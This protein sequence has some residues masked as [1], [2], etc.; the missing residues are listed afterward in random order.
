MNKVLIAEYTIF[1]DPSLSAEGEAM[2]SSLKKSFENCGYEVVSPE[3]GNFNSEIER[4]APECDYGLV[5][6]PDHLLSKFTHTLELA[7]H[8]LGSDST[9][10]AVCANKRLSSKLLENAGIKVPRETDSNYTGKRVIKPIRGAGSLRVRIAKDGEMPADDEMSVEYIVGDHY[11]VSIVGSRVIGD[12]CE[13][14]SGLPPVFLTV[15]KQNSYPDE[16]GSFVYK[17][18]ETPVHPQREA[19]IIKTARRALEILGCQGYTGIDIIDSP[20]GIYVVDVNARPTMSLIGI[21]KVIEEEIADVLLKATVG[22]P[23]E[24]VHYNGKTAYFDESG[25]VSVK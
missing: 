8:N 4:L 10:T 21:T 3:D 18:G 15:N 9:S 5:I 16:N 12:A 6:A 24:C 20:D 11:S 14:Y 2:L 17:G 22:Q 19:E 25:G 13:F 1:S 7:T 23:P